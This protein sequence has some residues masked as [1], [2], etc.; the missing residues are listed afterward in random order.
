MEQLA[1]LPWY[2]RS[3]SPR[4]P[5]QASAPCRPGSGSA[6][7]GHSTSSRS[8][9]QRHPSPPSTLIS[10]KLGVSLSLTQRGAARTDLI[11][12]D[13]AHHAPARAYA[14]WLSVC[15]AHRPDGPR[16]LG[17][18]ATPYRLH[19]GSIE[20]LLDFGFS[21]P[22]VPIF[23]V[24]AYQK[25]FCEL[26]AAG[27]CALFRHE[28][29][30]TGMSFPMRLQGQTGD[31]TSESLE[32]LDDPKRN[33]LIYETWA[34]NR[35]RYGKTLIFVGTQ[36]HAMNLAR[37]FGPTGSYVISDPEKMSRERRTETVDRFRRGEFAVLVNVG[38][39]KEG[40]DVPDIRT[41]VLARPTTSPGLFVQM[42]G[43]GSRVIQGKQ[44]F[45]LVDIHDQ[46]DRYEGYLARPVDL[47]N[48]DE[49]LLEV[50]EQRARAAEAI[51]RLRVASV[52][53]DVRVLLDVLGRPPKTIITEFAGWIVFDGD[54]REPP[55]AALLTGREYVKLKPLADDQ[56]SV[57]PHNAEAVRRIVGR[58]AAL[59]KCARALD[60]GLRGTLHQ[61]VPGD[62]EQ[63]A[64]L[65]VE[66]RTAR[67]L[68]SERLSNFRNALQLLEQKRV[69]WESP[70]LVGARVAAQLFDE[71]DVYAGVIRLGRPPRAYLRLV[72]HDVLEAMR[73]AF[74][75]KRVQ[76][77][78]LTASAA[79]DV[80]EEVKRRQADLASCY[81][82]LLQALVDEQHL[83][84]FSVTWS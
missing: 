76:R 2:R 58:S 20:R 60:E 23:E 73:R 43:R 51:D 24:I 1:G 48:R 32:G 44:F 25:S 38:I 22:R 69:E 3:R 36:R 82:L 30:D 46:L 61:F 47:A 59:A 49:R 18:T 39:F 70:E 40:V 35:E 11:V 6:V 79:R 14:E 84:D 41:V 78:R 8:P 33:R 7:A 13:E 62:D 19:E 83:S 50:V 4:S 54:R 21:R 77:E 17:L 68:S 12:I 34:R 65:Q 63:L 45:Y 29:L 15:R 53:L 56:G 57:F 37:L 75:L 81:E 16:V 64:T 10:R 72:R 9:Y 42:V 55:V 71:A 5:H 52:A 67:G 27:R 74:E 28:R 66:A 26:A 80:L 31:F